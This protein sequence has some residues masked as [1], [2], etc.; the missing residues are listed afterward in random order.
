[1]KKDFEVLWLTPEEVQEKTKEG[2]RCFCIGDYGLPSAY[3]TSPSDGSDRYMVYDK[4]N[5]KKTN[6]AAT[7]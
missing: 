3:V 4:K 1:M 5:K 7:A 6:K 2:F